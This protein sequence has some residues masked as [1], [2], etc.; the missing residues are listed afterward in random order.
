MRASIDSR[1]VELVDMTLDRICANHRAA[2]DIPARFAAIHL[3]SLSRLRE[4]AGVRAPLPLPL[5]GEGGGEGLQQLARLTPS[6]RDPL[7]SGMAT[8]PVASAV[9]SRITAHAISMPAEIGSSRN[10]K[11]H[12]IPNT[13]IR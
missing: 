3:H 12:S 10:I 1:P 2:R 6:L 5:A 13:G 7:R 8:L 11:P 4:R 9:P